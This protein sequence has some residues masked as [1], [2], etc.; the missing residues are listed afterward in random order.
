MDNDWKT[1]F[2]IHYNHG[3]RLS[4]LTCF[5]TWYQRMTIASHCDLCEPC[6]TLNNKNDFMRYLVKPVPYDIGYL[7]YLRCS[8]LPYW[9]GATKQL[10]QTRS[11]LHKQSTVW[12]IGVHWK[13][14]SLCYRVSNFR[15]LSCPTG[16]R[17]IRA[18]ATGY[19]IIS[20]RNF[21]HTRLV[22][23]VARFQLNCS[24]RWSLQSDI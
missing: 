23:N 11:L 10:V 14:V 18:S 20:F 1:S 2:V 8:T 15:A 13:V 5:W 21:G 17:V 4:R 9:P 3:T 6:N 24:E 19:T 22:A 12:H 16:R 7:N